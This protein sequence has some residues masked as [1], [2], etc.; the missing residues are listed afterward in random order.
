MAWDCNGGVPTTWTDEN[1]NA[2]ANAFYSGSVADPYYRP[3][4]ISDPEGNAVGLTYGLT[5]A[6]A[7]LNFNGTVSYNSPCTYL[8]SSGLAPCT[9]QLRV[10]GLAGNSPPAAIGLQSYL[11]SILGPNVQVAVNSGSQ[12]DYTLSY[13]PSFLAPAEA[14]NGGDPG[15]VGWTSNWGGS[16]LDSGYVLTD[17]LN[18]QLAT[19]GGSYTLGYNRVGAH[20]ISHFLLNSGDLK[21][22]GLGM[23]SWG[24]D[25][26]NPNTNRFLPTSDQLAKIKAKCDQLHPRAGG[27]GGGFNPEGAWQIG[28]LDVW[29]GE[30]WS[31]LDY[32][33]YDP[34]DN[35]IRPQVPLRNQ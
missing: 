1:G 21:F 30:G 22:P 19:N 27:G 8:D 20:E 29:N 25:V 15:T 23:L 6:E 5:S 32:F 18:Q 16:A 17:R 14:Y 10:T 28:E 2:V 31:F 11:N 35:V 24:P 7:A 34:G 9:L 33:Y 26:G 12:P 4:S 3:L 13:V